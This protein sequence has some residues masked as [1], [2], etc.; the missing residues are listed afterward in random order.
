[1]IYG[2]TKISLSKNKKKRKKDRSKQKMK[3][4]KEASTK[5][6]TEDIESVTTKVE[7][8]RYK[9]IYKIYKHEKEKETI[10]IHSSIREDC[11]PNW[12]I[13]QIKKIKNKLEI[14][15][16]FSFNIHTNDEVD[17]SKNLIVIRPCYA[18]KGQSGSPLYKM[19]RTKY[20]EGDQYTNKHIAVFSNVIK[21]EMEDSYC[22]FTKLK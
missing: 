5:E 9:N 2:I 4:E 16:C 19:R 1:M 12:K 7:S 20:K 13:T 10:Y 17:E 22:I 3:K 11:Q 6:N 8:K 15:N 14:P 21:P 18:D